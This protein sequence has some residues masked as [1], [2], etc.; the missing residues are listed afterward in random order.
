MGDGTCINIREDPWF[1]K[2]TT[3]KVRP[4]ECLQGTMVS[5]L[6]NPNSKSLKTDVISAC[7]N[8]DDVALILSIPLSK[9][10]CCDKLV[11][12]HI[13]N[14]DY[15]VKSGYRVVVSL[16]E[17]GAL[18]RKGRGAPSENRKHNQVWNKIW[19]LQVPNKIKIFIWRC[20]NNALAVRRNL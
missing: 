10:G 19:S 1:P 3:F 13:V 6:I 17:N 16:M 15:L 7:F 14:G 2:P 12:P 11:W 5:D 8:R 18:G 9:T 4:R 20:C